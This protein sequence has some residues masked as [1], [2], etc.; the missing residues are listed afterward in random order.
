M[1]PEAELGWFFKEKLGLAALRKQL[2]DTA[3]Q[4]SES[5]TVIE[6]ECLRLF[7]DLRSQDPLFKRFDRTGRRQ[8]H[9]QEGF[10]LG[11][12]GS[13]GGGF[14]DIDFLQASLGGGFSEFGS[15]IFL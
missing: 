1:L 2:L 12:Y 4:G 10:L 15:A 14:D 7:R 13:L 8:A 5:Y 3:L 11:V 9:H 6:S